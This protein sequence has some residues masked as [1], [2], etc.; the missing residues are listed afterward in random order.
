MTPLIS[1]TRY[2]LFCEP[3]AFSSNGQPF[4]NADFTHKFEGKCLFHRLS[5]HE[6]RRDVPSDCFREQINA[7]DWPRAFVTSDARINAA[8]PDGPEA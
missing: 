5:F 7:E 2:L 4:A 3:N 8:R 1:E 6:Y